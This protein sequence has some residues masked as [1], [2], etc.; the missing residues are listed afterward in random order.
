VKQFL[1]LICSWSFGVAVLAAASPGL[2]PEIFLSDGR[3]VVWIE[4]PTNASPRALKVQVEQRGGQVLSLAP[5]GRMV[6]ALA[7]TDVASFSKG[8]KLTPAHVAS[9]LALIGGGLKDPGLGDRPPTPK[10]KRHIDRNVVPV[11]TIRSSPLSVQRA[12]LEGAASSPSA[13]D[14]SLSMYFPP[15]GDQGGQGSCTAWAACYYYNTYTQARDENID[16]SGGSTDNINSP[17][18]MYPL[19]NG[20]VDKGANTEYVVQRLSSVGCCSCTLKPYSDTDYTS[21]PT[22]AA[23]VNA[24]NRR[25]TTSHRI[26]SD[27]GATDSDVDAIKQHLANGNVLVTRDGCVFQLASYIHG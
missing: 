20:G 13:V 5:E 2:E 15:I 8:L 18:F 22:E 21:W 19:V 17:A 4:L 14:N 26:G 7:K 24:L 27:S 25:T 6:V 3:Q 16:V 12:E 23:W 10:E 11:Q 9:A 1:A